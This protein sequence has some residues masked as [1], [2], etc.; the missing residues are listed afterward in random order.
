MVCPFLLDHYTGACPS[1]GTT[2]SRS[3]GARERSTDDE[4]PSICQGTRPR[5]AF[6]RDHDRLRRRRP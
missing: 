2:D 6:P 5:G 4:A 3:F 1:A